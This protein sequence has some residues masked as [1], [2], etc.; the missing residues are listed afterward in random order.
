MGRAAIDSFTVRQTAARL[1]KRGLAASGMFFSP[2]GCD[3]PESRTFSTLTC[4]IATQT[5][6]AYCS[7]STCGRSCLSKDA[8]VAPEGGLFLSFVDAILSLTRSS[9]RPLTFFPQVVRDGFSEVPIP[10]CPVSHQTFASLRRTV[11]GW[12]WHTLGYGYFIGLCHMFTSYVLAS[13]PFSLSPPFFPSFA[14]WMMRISNGVVKVGF[15]VVPRTDLSHCTASQ[16]CVSKR[17][18]FWRLRIDWRIYLLLPQRSPEV[19]LEERARHLF[20]T[21]RSNSVVVEFGHGWPFKNCCVLH[22]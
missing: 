8:V 13:F 22:L 12:S 20:S 1:E 2:Q 14:V 21:F 15:T 19:I 10:H 6:R 3:S 17:R 16:D 4:H 7:I 5:P 9:C 11:T 18:S